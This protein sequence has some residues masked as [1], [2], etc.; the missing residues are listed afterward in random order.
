MTMTRRRNPP[1]PFITFLLV[2]SASPLVITSVVAAT[3][4]GDDDRD[5]ND[6]ISKALLSYLF[7][8][9]YLVNTSLISGRGG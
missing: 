7:I 5:K 3:V 9:S 6:G 4:G 8:F 1:H 2:V